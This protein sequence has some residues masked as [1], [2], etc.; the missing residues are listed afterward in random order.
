MTLLTFH[1]SLFLL[2]ENHENCK[3]S[4]KNTHQG[5]LWIWLAVLYVIILA[6]CIKIRKADKG[7]RLRMERLSA[8]VSLGVYKRRSHQVF[9]RVHSWQT[10][11]TRGQLNKPELSVHCGGAVTMFS[12]G[13][14]FKLKLE[15][16][17]NGVTLQFVISLPGFVYNTVGMTTKQ[18]LIKFFIENLLKKIYVPCSAV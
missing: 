8:T 7:Y 13:H 1:A 5:V 14:C 6:W 10:C 3:S 9:T 4:V 17:E 18:D 15:M 2:H 12:R 16:P 11:Q